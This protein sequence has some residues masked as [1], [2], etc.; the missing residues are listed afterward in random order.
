[1]DIFWPDHLS[2]TTDVID[3]VKI[4]VR[5]HIISRSFQRHF[6]NLY[7][8]FFSQVNATRYKLPKKTC[9]KYFHL[10]YIGKIIDGTEEVYNLWAP[11]HL[12]TPFNLFNLRQIDIFLGA[13]FSVPIPIILLLEM[14]DASDEGV[15]C[16]KEIEIRRLS[17]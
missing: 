2:A 3:Y 11:S 5:K 14:R 10:P 12:T 17:F 7:S 9:G 4:K 1:M 8:W 13:I 16:F 15:H 6:R